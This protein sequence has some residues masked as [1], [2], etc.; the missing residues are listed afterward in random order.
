MKMS[1]FI[2]AI[3]VLCAWSVLFVGCAT[4]KAPTDLGGDRAKTAGVD[5]ARS[6]IK[7]VLGRASG[8]DQGFYLLG[9]I[10]LKAVSESRAVD[11]MYDNA[12]SR[13]AI[14][15]GNSRVFANTSLEKAANYFVLFSV[16]TY[17]ATGDVVE[18][19]GSPVKNQK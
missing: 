7:L 19:V 9:F 3:P 10:P 5:I 12:K 4:T 14:L 2:A 15:E 1:K 6:D 8:S 16:P 18:Y 13:G 17:R 11:S